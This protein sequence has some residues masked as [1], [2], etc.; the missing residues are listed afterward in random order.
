[1]PD[2]NVKILLSTCHS[3]FSLS[4]CFFLVILSEAKNLAS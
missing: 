4:F 2:K 3:A 1:M